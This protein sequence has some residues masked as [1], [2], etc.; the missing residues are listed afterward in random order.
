M[1]F[2]Q[3]PAMSFSGQK[4][5]QW[6]DQEWQNFWARSNPEGLMGYYPVQE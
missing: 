6:T 4:G 2:S 5:P 1:T 3:S